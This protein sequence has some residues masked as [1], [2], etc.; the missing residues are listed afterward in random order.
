MN[1]SSSIESSDFNGCWEAVFRSPSGND[2]TF[3]LH[4]QNPNP[5]GDVFNPSL[6]L[7]A[8][9]SSS[10][11]RHLNVKFETVARLFAE[12]GKSPFLAMLAWDPSRMGMN[13]IFL[14]MTDSSEWNGRIAWNSITA[15]EVQ[16]SPIRFMQIQQ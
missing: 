3:T 10:D 1:K 12:C 14:Q 5:K 16:H 9:R 2:H 7:D 6:E 4:L 13:T 8:D 11:G 15:G